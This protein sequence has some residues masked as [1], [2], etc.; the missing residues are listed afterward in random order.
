MR[1][2]YT[3]EK[4]GLAMPEYIKKNV[5]HAIREEVC[6]PST[7]SY[8]ASI[9]YL[10]PAYSRPSYFYIIRKIGSRG[11][12]PVY[13]KITPIV[14]ALSQALYENVNGRI[15]DC[16][17]SYNHM[18][19]AQLACE[20]DNVIIQLLKG[21]NIDINYIKQELNRVNHL[22]KKNVLPRKYKTK[23]KEAKRCIE[24]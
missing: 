12:R 5:W 1:S 11:S 3:L 21:N 17:A 22:I 7:C 14:N 24:T 15:F 16:I 10:C 18:V 19:I 23:S 20:K 9:V 6:F 13:C 2:I 8:S 4:S